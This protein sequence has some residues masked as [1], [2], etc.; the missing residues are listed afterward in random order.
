MKIKNFFDTEYKLFSIYDNVRS[1]P[2]VIDGLKVSQRKIIHGMLKRGESAGEFKVENAGNYIASVTDYHHGANSLCST[3]VNLAQ[4]FA[5]SNNIN[6]L[7]PIG[8]F[9][10]RLDPEAGAGRYIFTELSNNFRKIFKKEDDI[11]LDY[12]Y[13][14]DL[15]IEPKLY[16]PILP[17]LLV[18]GAKGTGTGYACNI[19]SYNPEDIRNQMISLLNGKKIKD[20]LIPWYRTYKGKITKDTNQTI[21]EGVYNIINATTI[22]ITELPIGTYQ[23][24]YRELL[25]DLE[26]AG[27]IKSYIDS[28]T[29]QGFDFL[30]NVPRSTT[31]MSHDELMKKFKLISRGT[32]TFSTW[33]ENGKIKVFNNPKEIIE[34]FTSFRLGIYEKRRLAQIDKHKQELVWINERLRFI[35]FYIS[36]SEL[37]SKKG[38]KELTDMLN[39]NKFVEVEKLLQ[40]RIYSLTKDEI[41]K[42]QAEKTETENKI[43]V[44]EGSSAKDL[45]I[46]ELQDLKF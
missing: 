27:F 22:H 41:E 23:D 3:I 6:L 2:S 9:G 35:N 11:I 28:S 1:I 24:D 45:F 33:D 16:Y 8:Q 13:S 36:N 21:I 19:F 39:E 31:G 15:Q 44:L 14:D 18:N 42:L 34:H 4:N 40:I 12:L 26:D 46:K 29:E 38:K 20:D 43:V 17:M 30:L 37:F 7:E 32:E 5:G 25:N 10:S